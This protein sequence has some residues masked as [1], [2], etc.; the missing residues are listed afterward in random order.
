MYVIIAGGKCVVIRRPK[1]TEGDWLIS[2]LRRYPRVAME[3][4]GRDN[5]R[6]VL[7]VPM[8]GFAKR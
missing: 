6:Q 7:E 2:D 3:H 1:A 8:A 4:P 5:L